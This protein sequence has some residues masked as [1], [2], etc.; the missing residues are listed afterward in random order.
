MKHDQLC[1]IGHNI[2]DSLASG[3]AFVI[4]YHPVDVFGEAAS[5][6]DGLIEIDFLRGRIVRGRASPNLRS[7][8]LGFAK[9]FPAFCRRNEARS[10]DFRELSG[11]FRAGRSILWVEVCVADRNGQRSSTNY[12]GIPL[13]RTWSLDPLGRRRRVPRKFDRPGG[14]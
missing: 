1:A 7:A 13:K 8:V 10:T 2:M 9:A 5:S 12:S 3:Q 6:E 11:T 14:E 4:G